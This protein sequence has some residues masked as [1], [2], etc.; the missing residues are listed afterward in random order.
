MIA[1]SHSTF[2]QTGLH[3]GSVISS[4]VTFIFRTLPANKK[5]KK[6]QSH[7]ECGG[8][9]QFMS[10]ILPTERQANHY[11]QIITSHTEGFPIL[12]REAE[13]ILY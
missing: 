9:L 5:N 7:Q 1:S 11:G 2:T 4:T 3:L 10:D 13:G 12:T 8:L 6:I